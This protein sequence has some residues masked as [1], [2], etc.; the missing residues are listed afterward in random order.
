MLGGKIWMESEKGEGSTFYFTLPYHRISQMP[1]KTSTMDYLPSHVENDTS[2]T[3]TINIVI[4][5]DDATSATYLATLVAGFKRNIMQVRSGKEAID[6]CRNVPGIDLILMDIKMADMDGYQATRLIRQ[7]NS[8]V[9]IIAQTAY[10]LA[11]D[12]EKAIAS[13]C[14]DYIE[15]PINRLQLKGL[16]NKYLSKTAR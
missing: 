16:V 13:G 5:E 4:A 9:I 6:T 10:A 14:N 3:P 2:H 7:F 12:R 8:E 15:K 1:N 11:G